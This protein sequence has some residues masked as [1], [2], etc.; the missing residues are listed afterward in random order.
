[1]NEC[2]I[3]RPRCYGISY[4]PSDGSCFYKGNETNTIALFNNSSLSSAIANSTQLQ[5][6][7]NLTCP[8][9]DNGI[10]TTDNGM[11]FQILCDQ[12]LKGIGDY[13]ATNGNYS[14]PLHSDSLDECLDLCANAHPLCRGVSWNPDMIDGYAN[15]YLKDSTSG[16]PMSD[17]VEGFIV[18][19]AEL[20]P[21]GLPQVDP[22]CPSN[23]TYSASSG[24]EFA[25]TCYDQ[26][27]NDTSF[28]AFHEPNVEQCMDLCSVS[29]GCKGVVLDL[30]MVGGY[31]NCYVSLL[32]DPI[33]FETFTD[34]AA[35]LYQLLNDTGASQLGANFTFAQ[36]ASGNTTS[37]VSSSSPKSKAWIAGPVIGVVAAVALL[38]GLG[39]WWRRRS[40]RKRN[41]Q[42]RVHQQHFHDDTHSL[43]AMK[44]HDNTHGLEVQEMDARESL[45]MLPADHV[46]YELPGARPELGA[47]PKGRP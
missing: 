42:Q 31:E 47:E 4:R 19:S 3:L 36:V 35:L 45:P 22:T 20:P 40:Q 39:L 6:P 21:S 41:P 16:D 23:L 33:K 12:D 18:H 27:T 37:V 13:C 2:A 11:E 8:Y 10:A 1:M 29:Q 9:L 28:V 34:R 44:R 46:L 43:G 32:M 38:L 7:T 26:R 15:C 24:T 25:I 5:S 17:A 14:C 30:A